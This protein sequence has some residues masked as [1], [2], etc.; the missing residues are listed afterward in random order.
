MLT[1]SRV[2]GPV[3]TNGKIKPPDSSVSRL[4]SSVE[5][6][7]KPPDKLKSAA[8]KHSREGKIKPPD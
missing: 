5:G 6:K 3:G 4:A 1:K 7:I 2:R 8:R